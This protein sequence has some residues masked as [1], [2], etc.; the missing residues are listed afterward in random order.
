MLSFFELKLS[1]CGRLTTNDF[2]LGAS[3]PRLSLNRSAGLPLLRPESD[4]REIEG[5]DGHPL[6][7]SGTWSTMMAPFWP[8]NAAF[9]MPVGGAHVADCSAL[10]P[11]KSV[12]TSEVCG[13]S[14]RPEKVTEWPL[15]STVPTRVSLFGAGNW[16]VRV[17]ENGPL[18]VRNAW[19]VNGVGISGEVATAV[20]TAMPV[21]W[22]P[23]EPE[24]GAI[25]GNGRVSTCPAP[26]A[27]SA[28]CVTVVTI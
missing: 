3:E 24:F 9:T 10:A 18:P 6:T 23:S 15:R 2:R 1:P 27:S 13:T 25:A 22:T 16:S 12:T 21:F 14:G 19:P 26:A 20:P 8:V 5:A 17:G 11:P 28:F 4:V 7:V